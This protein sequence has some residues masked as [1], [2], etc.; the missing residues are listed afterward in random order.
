MKFV[1]DSSS[2][3]PGFLSLNAAG[4]SIT[5]SGVSAFGNFT[6]EVLPVE[7]V[8]STSS[9]IL[10]AKVSTQ[11]DSDV[12]SDDLFQRLLFL[13]KQIAKELK[14]PAYVIFNDNTLKEMVSRMPSDLAEMKEV[15]GVGQSKLDK[16]GDKFLEAILQFGSERES[17][18]S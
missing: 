18:I 16:Y 15:S 8:S 2:A 5:V 12:P 13:R 11:V 4:V 17:V 9:D 6:I 3:F 1:I 14:L 7:E 10:E